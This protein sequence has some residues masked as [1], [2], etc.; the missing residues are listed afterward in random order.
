M[1]KNFKIKNQDFKI[2]IILISCDFNDIKDF[3][4]HLKLAIPKEKLVQSS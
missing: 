4:K 2:E 1:T 3:I